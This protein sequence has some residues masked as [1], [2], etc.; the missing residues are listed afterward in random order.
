MYCK[1]CDSGDIEETT[2]WQVTGQVDG[3][4]NSTVVA[5]CKGCGNRW[6]VEE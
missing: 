1:K 2:M 5:T 6:V 3:Q 4:R